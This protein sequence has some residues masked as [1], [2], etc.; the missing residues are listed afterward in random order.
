[1]ELARLLET[2]EYHREMFDIHSSNWISVSAFW[3][4]LIS[5]KHI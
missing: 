3:Y 1:M 5:N 4:V 2:H